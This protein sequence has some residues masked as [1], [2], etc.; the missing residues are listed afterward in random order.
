MMRAWLFNRI[1]NLPNKPV[2]LAALT[3]YGSAGADQPAKPFLMIQMGVEQAPL[4]MPAESRTQEIPFTV[5]VHDTG[6]SMLRIDDACVW[7]KNNLPMDIGVKVGSMSVY[8]IKWQDTGQDGYDDFFKTN[9]R[10][11]RFTMMTRR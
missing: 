2:S 11:V 1:T 8:E 7:L 4:G 3:I 9:T 6:A 5:W 10:P